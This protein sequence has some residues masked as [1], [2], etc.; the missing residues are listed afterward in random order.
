MRPWAEKLT[1]GDGVLRPERIL[2]IVVSSL[3]LCQ[4]IIM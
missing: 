4:A 1:P 2:L 3:V